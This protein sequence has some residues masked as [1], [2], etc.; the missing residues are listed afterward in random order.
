MPQRA[1][2]QAKWHPLRASHAIGVQDASLLYGKRKGARRFRT[3]FSRCYF[4]E[5]AMEL[6]TNKGYLRVL[7]IS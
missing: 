1:R 6:R 2:G 4:S 5:C 7:R 3:P